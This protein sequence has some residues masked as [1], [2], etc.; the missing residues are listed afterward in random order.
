M[1]DPRG[2]Q[3]N[4]MGNRGAGFLDRQADKDLADAL[5]LVADMLGQS[6]TAH[7]GIVGK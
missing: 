4:P 7:T 2:G 3:V 5:H 6:L 1:R